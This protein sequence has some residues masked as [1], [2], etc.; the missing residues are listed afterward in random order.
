ME[1]ELIDSAK[2][3]SNMSKTLET[4]FDNI[5]D[6]IGLQDNDHNIIKYNKAGYDF[7]K[8]SFEEVKGKKCFELIQRGSPCEQCATSIVYETKKP[9]RVERYFEDLQ[10]WLDIRAYPILNEKGEIQNIIEHLRDITDQKKAVEEKIKYEKQIQHNQ[11]LES[12]GIL[13]G[14]IAHDFNNL[15]FGIYGYIDIARMKTSEPKIKKY[16][17]STIKTL[18]RAK[19]LTQQLLTFSKG[20]EPEIKVNNLNDFLKD[21]VQFALSGSK[22]SSE[23]SINEDLWVCEFDANQMGQVIDNIVINAQQAM[24]SGGTISVIADNIKLKKNE[25]NILTEGKYIRIQIK[26]Q[27]IGIPQ[28]IID[29]IFDPFFTTKKIGSGLGLATSYSIVKKHK[30]HIDVESTPEKGSTFT[31]CLPASEKKFQDEKNFKTNNINGTGK[32]LVMDDEEI[33]RNTLKEMLDYFGFATIES[34][35]GTEAIGIFKELKNNKDELAAIF[36]DI[37]IPGG[38]GGKEAIKHIRDID[39]T[40]PV[41]VSSG[42]SEDPI[43]QNPEKFGF[44]ASIQKPFTLE[45]LKNTIFKYVIK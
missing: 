8:K 22:I 3:N 27:G 6:I 13:A 16:L 19:N 32:V 18:S 11:K 42:Y 7:L 9:A 39:S 35:D 29:R 12:L 23:I 25:H 45:D 15:L 21:T 17:D 38:M 43:I 4:L 44:T 41:I 20:G 37:T 28:S 30:G 2:E 10:I 24:P 5:P 1:K 40:I 31:I 34:C 33:I 36:L 14:G 26:D